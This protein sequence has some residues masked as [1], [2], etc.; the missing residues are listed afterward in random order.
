MVRR[1]GS[2]GLLHN[3]QVRIPGLW[4]IARNHPKLILPKPPFSVGLHVCLHQALHLKVTW[5][6]PSKGFHHQTSCLVAEV[7]G[8]RGR[9]SLAPS[10]TK[11]TTKLHQIVSDCMVMKDIPQFKQNTFCHREKNFNSKAAW[12]RPSKASQQ[13]SK[14]S[15]DKRFS[16]V[17]K[18][19][20]TGK[21]INI[22]DDGITPKSTRLRNHKKFKPIQS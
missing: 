4:K 13:A 2:G 15:S 11:E 1:T 7:V 8:N 18:E 16:A 12:Q 20:S 5:S 9:A 21:W 10:P 22:W 14:T 3:P 6:N 17:P 19:M